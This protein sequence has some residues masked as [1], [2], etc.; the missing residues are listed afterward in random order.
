MYILPKAIYTLN[1]ISV[2]IPHDIFQRTTTNNPRIYMKPR[3]L[4]KDQSNVEKE[5][6]S[7]RYH[8]LWLQTILQ[9]FSNSMYGTDTKQYV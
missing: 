7:W 9:I 3:K 4:L 6:Q 5:E 8:T 2:K 1:A